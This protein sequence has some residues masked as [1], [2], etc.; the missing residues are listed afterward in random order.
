MEIQ[1]KHKA[2]KGLRMKHVLMIGLQLLERI[3]DLHS[4]N[5][6]HGDLKPANIMFGRRD[7]K[8]RL[9]LIDFGLTREESVEDDQVSIF[10]T[11]FNVAID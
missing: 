3:R 8:N 4:L 1:R 10:K 7:C 11:A 5:L 9:Y 6:V 2:T